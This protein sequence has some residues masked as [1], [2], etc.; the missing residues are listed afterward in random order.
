[1]LSRL[2]SLFPARVLAELQELAN[3]ITK[4]RQLSI[5]PRAQI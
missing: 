1:M 4:I 3:A 2:E 5:F